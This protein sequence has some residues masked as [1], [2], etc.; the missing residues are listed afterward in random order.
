M[1]I[2][3]IDDYVVLYLLYVSGYRC[4]RVRSD[5]PIGEFWYIS[6]LPIDL[7]GSI[8]FPAGFVIKAIYGVELRATKKSEEKQ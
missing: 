6:D 4:E 8:E 2:W 1:R 3:F 5:G 7:N